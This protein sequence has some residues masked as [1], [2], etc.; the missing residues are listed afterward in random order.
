MRQGVSALKKSLCVL[1][2][3]AVL[4]VA[5]VPA[6]GQ[7]SGKVT[8]TVT[9]KT[10]PNVGHH[11]PW[12]FTTK[13]EVKPPKGDCPPGTTDTTYCTPD[14]DKDKA[15]KG[16]VR[17]RFTLGTKVVSSK[18]VKLGKKCKYSAK[19]TIR[20]KSLA[21]K[22]LR[23]RARFLGNAV[24]NPANSKSRRVLLARHSSGL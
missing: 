13:G 14:V 4:A 10:K 20:G 9:R 3:A 7:S 12:K 23:V 24:L 17:V 16:K 5:A 19:Q 8:P 18:T 15:C 1:A 21:G 11:Y 6:V 22:R 2:G